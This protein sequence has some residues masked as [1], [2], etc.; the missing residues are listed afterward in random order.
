MLNESSLVDL[1]A[2]TSNL[3]LHWK[4]PSHG[5]A[6]RLFALWESF[7]NQKSC[8]GAPN[9]TSIIANGSWVVD[10]F[11]EAGAKLHTSFFE[12]NILSGEETKARLR[13]VRA[14][15]EYRGIR[16]RDQV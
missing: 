12:D 13:D 6:W 14:L 5:K 2:Q 10:H 3:S 7:T 11:S 16:F 9:A 8:S 1:T 4:A 15:G